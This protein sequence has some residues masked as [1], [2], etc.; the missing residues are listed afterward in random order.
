MNNLKTI[1][2]VIVIVLF[3]AGVIWVAKPSNPNTGTADI[4]QAAA[5][6]IAAEEP[7]FNFGEI[8]M[9]KGKV[10]HQFKIKNDGVGPLKIEKIYTSCMCTTAKLISAGRSFGPYGMPGHGFIPK[11]SATISQNEEAIVEAVFDPA[12]HGPSGIGRIER[13]VYL[14]NSGGSPLELT[15]FATVT[16]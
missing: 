11:I 5:G 13:A 12:A 9:S 3:F 4:N 8:S 10:S 2:G 14:E 6:E 15:F 1:I 7:V 16:P